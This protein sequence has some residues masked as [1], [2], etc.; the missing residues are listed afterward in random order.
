LPADDHLILTFHYYD[1][2]EFTHQGAP[3]AEGAAEWKGRKWT[4]NEA[5]QAQVR[6][7]FAEV[8][9]WAASTSGRCS[10]ASLA[11]IKRPT[12]NRVPAGPVSSP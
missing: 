1:P 11:F 10:S 9:K 12:W 5:E 6:K 7:S 4:G 2:F 3:W 8:V